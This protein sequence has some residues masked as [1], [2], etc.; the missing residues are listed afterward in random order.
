MTS[1]SISI[2]VYQ[3]DLSVLTDTLSSL[4]TAVMYARKRIALKKCQLT[5]VDNG[6]NTQYHQSLQEITLSRF[7][8]SHFSLTFKTNHGN[9][10]F[11]RGHNIAIFSSNC[12]Y[13]LVL[14]PDVHLEKT[15]ISHALQFM[16]HKTAIGLLV[17]QCFHHSGCQQFLIKSYP[18][19]LTL[20][21]RGLFP[22]FQ[23]NKI[24]N[25]VFQPC[26]GN[27]CQCNDDWNHIKILKDELVSGC[28]MFFK[29]THLKK[30]NG[31]SSA[32]FLYF[33]D[34]D[35][36]LRLQTV[37]KIVYNPH[38]KIVH[39]GGNTSQKGIWHIRQFILSGI[40]FFSIHGWRIY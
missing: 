9:I 22:F 31:F 23:K 21:I 20:A 8:A 4:A 15:A 28:F 6:M 7:P 11:G 29:Q 32:F 30:I 10:G 33:E 39:F 3:S 17:P 16:K 5:L 36:S 14:N 18:S 2:V 38:V 37:S 12:D 27:Y 26:L 24:F 1:L 40:K 19:L 25:K 35:L 34:F 13:H